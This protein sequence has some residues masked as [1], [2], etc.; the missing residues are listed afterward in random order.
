MWRTLQKK[1]SGLKV[2]IIPGISSVT[3]A[4]ASAIFP[5][6][7]Q[8][9]RVA[10]ISGE[11]DDQFIRNTLKEF[12]TVV[13]LKVSSIFDRLAAILEDMG[14]ADNCVYVRRS[15]LPGEQI[16]RDIRKLKNTKLDY[17]SI[18]LVRRKTG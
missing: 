15:S 6:A 7:S 4:A 9:E 10:I 13:F 1:Y 2:E 18:L 5:L 3:S 11:K 16:I 12:D 17:F 8:N 14:L